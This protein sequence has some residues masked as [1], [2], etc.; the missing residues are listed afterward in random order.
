MGVRGR[1]GSRGIAEDLREGVFGAVKD[2]GVENGD[3]IEVLALGGME[4]GEIDGE[5]VS[6][7]RGTAAK[8]DF[9]EDDRLA[10]C[11]FGMVVGWGHAVDVEEGEQ[12]EVVAF[13]VEEAQAETFGFGVRDGVGAKGAQLVV[14]FGD[15]SLG[16]PE[17][18]FAYVTLTSKITRLRKEPAEVVAKGDGDGVGFAGG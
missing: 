7:L 6:P 4:D 1:P 9:P 5:C 18:D 15:M 11:L 13:G 3:G 16:G 14:E 12:A 2:E 17:G 10:E 8:D